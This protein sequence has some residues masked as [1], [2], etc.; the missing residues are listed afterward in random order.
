MPVGNVPPTNVGAEYT[1]SV[2]VNVPMSPLVSEVVPAATYVPAASE[3]IVVTEPTDE[4]MTD[5][6]DIWL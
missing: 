6:P 3:P 2:Y 4:T 1:V 5:D